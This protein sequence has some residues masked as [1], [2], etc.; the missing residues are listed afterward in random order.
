M[1]NPFQPGKINIEDQHMKLNS[2]FSH[3]F[4]PYKMFAI[5]LLTC[6]LKDELDFAEE[7]SKT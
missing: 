3:P 1:K 2:T 7:A 4:L 5:T 6:I